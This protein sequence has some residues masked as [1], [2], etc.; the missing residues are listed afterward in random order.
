MSTNNNTP[1]PWERQ[2]G[3]TVKAFE[4]FCVYRDLGKTRSQEKTAEKLSKSRQQMCKWS[5]KYNWVERVSAWEE[6]QDRLIRVE[7]T[8]DIGAM[9][10]KHADIANALLIK[11]ASALRKIPENEIKASDISKMIET[12]TKLERISKGDVGEVIEERTGGEAQDPV[13]FYIPDNGR[14][15]G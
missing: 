14:D 7:L 5:M 10:K 12:A 1:R 2:N 15:N 8:K 13:Q 9:R 6:E 4:A 3:E 11:A